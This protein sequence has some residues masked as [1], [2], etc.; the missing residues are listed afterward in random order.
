MKYYTVWCP[1]YGHKSADDG[2]TVFASSPEYAAKAWAERSS[3]NK[4]TDCMIANGATVTYVV[5]D[6]GGVETR[7][8]VSAE[9]SVTYYAR[10]VQP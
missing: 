3:S 1:D 10:E 5:V 4:S 6:D 7:F 9:P 8:R 2:V